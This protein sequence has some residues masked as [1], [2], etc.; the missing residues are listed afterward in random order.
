MSLPDIQ[1][2]PPSSDDATTDNEI[3]TKDLVELEKHSQG[4]TTPELVVLDVEDDYPDG[5][6]RAW[7]VVAG[8]SSSSVKLLRY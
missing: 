1:H 2:A 8:V 3:D 5:G 4:Y 6:L 7:L